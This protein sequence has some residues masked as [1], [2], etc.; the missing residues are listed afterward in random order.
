MAGDLTA[1][2]GWETPKDQ[3]RKEARARSAVRR[4]AVATVP[5]TFP[6]T[7]DEWF[8]RA[9]AALTAAGWEV[10]AW[11]GGLCGAVEALNKLERK[12]AK[13]ASGGRRRC[14]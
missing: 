14:R 2:P 9:R 8:E 10:P 1:E 7:P 5:T 6:G 4:R 12:A 3:A 13:R 11:E